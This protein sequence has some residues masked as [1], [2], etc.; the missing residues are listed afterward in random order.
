MPEPKTSNMKKRLAQLAVVVVALVGVCSAQSEAAV[1]VAHHGGD[2]IE[3]R[4]VKDK[5][6]KHHRAE[7]QRGHRMCHRHHVRHNHGLRCIVRGCDFGGYDR[8]HRH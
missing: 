5:G 8:R 1:V 2:R 7:K 4:M 6:H 3:H